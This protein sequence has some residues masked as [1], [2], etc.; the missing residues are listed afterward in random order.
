[1]NAHLL[2]EEWR[3][4][5]SHS[6]SDSA[7]RE[8][9]ASPIAIVGMAAQFGPWDDTA[10]SSRSTFWA[11]TV[12]E[13][14][15][16]GTAGHWREASPPSTGHGRTAHSRS[17]G[18][19]FRRRNWKRRCPQ[20]LL[21]L[22]VAAAALEDAAGPAS[23][24]AEISP[25]RTGAFVGLGLDL[26]TTN[27]HL[28]WS[29]IAAGVSADRA[30]LRSRRTGRWWRSAASPRVASPVRSTSVGR[31]TPSAAKKPPRLVRWNS[32]FEP[33]RTASSIASVVGGVDLAC[34][35]RLVLPGAVDRPGDGAA[36]FVLKR[37]A[38]AERDGRSNI[39][40]HPRNRCGWRCGELPDS[41]ATI[42]ARGDFKDAIPFDAA[43]VSAPSCDVRRLSLAKACLS[44]RH[45]TLPGDSPQYWLH[46]RELA[47]GER[48]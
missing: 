28:R 16:K 9:D 32:A 31:V 34:D 7:R 36:A 19:A 46:D 2:L 27:F 8:L 14:K 17:T 4:T 12:A 5:K 26:N 42:D 47:L 38:D 15:P 37:L 22:Q 6:R 23:K 29:S 30:G 13:A 35:P 41:R 25:V 43:M 10:R 11:D 3:D 44:L 18:S 20:Q 24:S 45:A 33:F 1:M 21:M 48:S 40:G 39:L